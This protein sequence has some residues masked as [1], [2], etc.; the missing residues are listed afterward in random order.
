[1]SFLNKSPRRVWDTHPASFPLRLVHA[2]LRKA[3]AGAPRPVRVLLISDG[4]AYTSEQQFAPIVRHAQALRD[5]LGVV[6]QYRKLEAGLALSAASLQRFDMVGLKL[7]FRTANEEAVRIARHFRQA[8]GTSSTRFVYFDGDDDVNVQWPQML[9]ACDVYVKKHVFTDAEA[10]TAR[11]T[12]K[13]NITD[14]V[15]RH[16]GVSFAED[17]IPASGGQDRAQLH[18]IHL[19]WNIGL[20][21][22]I[23]DLAR[24]MSA[25]PST[26]KD[27]DIGCR[28]YA[29]PS[30][31][32]AP[33]RNAA[34]ERI[35]TLG[36]RFKVQAPRDRVSQEEYYQEML[37]A[38]I[39][40]SPFGFGEICW[41]DFEAILCGCLLVKPDMGHMKTLPNIFIPGVTYVPVRWDYS[42]LESVCADYL[43]DDAKRSQV[44]ARAREALLASLQADWFVDVFGDL[45]ERAGI[46]GAA[47]VRPS[48][49][50]G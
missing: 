49:A 24:R 18:K 20:D 7:S 30:V 47:L 22:K 5:R 43:A 10:Y 39:C 48:L 41:R 23:A 37:R 12:G 14:H 26:A 36:S 19:G 4:Q 27:I 21:D 50:Q 32:I 33:I 16:H 29:N 35:E 15:A 46:G 3:I 38:R 44:V 31:W 34:V 13:S 6:V 45:L 11:Y 42:D 40:V 28:A 2:Q 25:P 1:M 8:L 9:E 17:I